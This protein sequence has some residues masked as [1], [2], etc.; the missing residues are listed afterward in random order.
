MAEEKVKK[1]P[2]GRWILN[3]LVFLMVAMLVF[4]ARDEII[5]AWWLLPNVNI[6]ILLLLIPMQ[7]LSYFAG[8]MIFWTFLQ[9][10]GKL[11]KYKLTEAARMSLELNFLNHIFPSGGISGV[12][13]IIWRLGKV[14]VGK[15]QA[16]MSQL[17]RVMATLVAFVLLLSISL[18]SVTIENNSDA[19]LMVL[20][21]VSVTAVVFIFLFSAYLVGSENRL[22]SFARWISKT[23]N[24]IVQKV[25]LGRVKKEAIPAD[26]MEYFA[27]EMH[28]D[29]LALKADKKILLKPMI[30]A[31]IFVISDVALFAIAFLALGVSFNPALVVIAYGAAMVV[32]AVMIT[33]GGAGGFEAV[34]ISVLAAGGMAAAGATSGVILARVILILGTLATGYVVYHQ[35]MKKY[36]K[37]PETKHE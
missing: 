20:T 27:I 33:P 37:P 5:E 6:L 34:M 17:V 7:I 32:G 31:L 9:G 11:E 28:K 12:T 36:G 8:G 18:I 30:W 24:K 16:V 14:G 15:G 21:A 23:G 3:G 35:A 1:Q 19:W 4:F 29:Y 2:I 26:R 13:Y 25:T 22:T 10:R